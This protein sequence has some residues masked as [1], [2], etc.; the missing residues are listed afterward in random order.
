MTSPIRRLSGRI[1]KRV[2]P[3]YLIAL[4]AGHGTKKRISAMMR[5]K[6]EATFLRTSVESI[7]AHVDEVVIIDNASSDE[8]PSIAAGLRAQWPRKIRVIG[9]PYAV[10]RVGVENSSLAKSMDKGSPRLLA[11]YYN[12]C[13]RQCRMNFILKWD[14]DM[15]ATPALERH[16]QIL[17]NSHHLIL[18][19]FGANVHPD[20]R[21][22]V[23]ASPTDQETIQNRMQAR[24]TVENWTSQY[25]D[26]EVRLFPK[27]LSQYRNDFWWCESLHTPWVHWPSLTLDPRTTGILT[28]NECGFLHLKYCKAGAFDN[29]SADFGNAIAAGIQTGPPIPP[30][31]NDLAASLP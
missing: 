17:R 25:T 18:R 20:R 16:L 2:V 7:V 28:P 13:L 8:T 19:V 31:L 29:F 11:N 27:F 12:W 6:N 21:H 10:A 23:S 4:I 9:Y 26:A 30:P 5:V 24:M 1:L 14:G 22:L 3:A 15:V